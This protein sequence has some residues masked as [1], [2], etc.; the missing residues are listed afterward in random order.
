[1]QK[2]EPKNRQEPGKIHLTDEEVAFCA[3][4]LL[5]GRYSDTVPDDIQH[6]MGGCYQCYTSVFDFLQLFRNQP[7]LVTALYDNEEQI[8]TNHEHHRNHPVSNRFFQNIKTHPWLFTAAAI[9]IFIAVSVFTW[10]NIRSTP[11]TIVAQ[12][13]APYHDVITSKT[14]IDNQYLA[15]GLFYYNTGDYAKAITQFTTGLKQSPNDHDLLFYLA[16]SYQATGDYAKAIAIYELLHEISIIYHSPV[17]WYLALSY[18]SLNNTDMA[19][20]LLKK[21]VNEGG[22]YANDASKILRK[23]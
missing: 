19:K 23:L 14:M 10:L 6:H 7:D 17:R 18:I 12:F 1:M 4:E 8:M 16:G 11:E 13:Y 2:N 3:Q 20:S 21:I 15:N 22:F 5:T 9:L